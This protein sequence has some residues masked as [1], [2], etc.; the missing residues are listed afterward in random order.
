[1]L[2]SSNRWV[3]RRIQRLFGDVDEWAI[4]WGQGN[5]Q[6][7]GPR[8][9]AIEKSSDLTRV[10]VMVIVRLEIVRLKG[11]T[12]RGIGGIVPTPTPLCID[13]HQP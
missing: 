5:C 8:T 6:R 4:L 3:V 1:M 13:Q 12:T 10:L 11:H 9:R 7:T 2:D